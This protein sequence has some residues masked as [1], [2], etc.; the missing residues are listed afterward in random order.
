MLDA[1]YREQPE[2]KFV[3]SDGEPCNKL[4]RGLLRRS[5]VVASRHRY[6]GKKNHGAGSK[7]T[8]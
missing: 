1:P 7:V 3:G 6:I 4:T 8:T 2:A 5:I